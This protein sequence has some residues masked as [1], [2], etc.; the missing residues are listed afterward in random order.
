M[1]GLRFNNFKLILWLQYARFINAYFLLMH[2]WTFSILK[3]SALSFSFFT[4]LWFAFRLIRCVSDSLILIRAGLFYFLVNWFVLLL[5]KTILDKRTI[6]NGIL[7][8]VFRF[9]LEETSFI[10]EIFAFFI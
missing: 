1:R 3:F 4:N 9:M 5:A 10:L 2:F 6:D 8:K 7:T